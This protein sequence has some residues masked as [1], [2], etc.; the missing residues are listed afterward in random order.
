MHK[1]G[2]VSL[3]LNASGAARAAYGY[4]P[5]GDK[6]AALT[7][8]DADE[9]AMLNPLRSAARTSQSRPG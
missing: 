2:P 3:L 5:C 4:R 6:D 9:S 8:G 7:K 1:N